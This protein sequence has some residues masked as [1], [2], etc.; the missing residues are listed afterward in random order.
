MAEKKA[1]PGLTIKKE[2]DFSGWYHELVSKCGLIDYSGIPGC[3]IL[4]PDA[5]FVWEQI[6]NFVNERIKKEGVCNAYFPLFIEE[7]KLQVEVDH[8]DG[9]KPEV[10]WVTE[11]GESQLEKRIA[12]RPT[13]E[14]AICPVVKN[15]IR[16]HRDLPL[17]LNQWCNV[18]RWEFKDCIPFIRSREFLWQEGHTFHKNRKDAEE[19]VTKMLEVYKDVYQD[20]L[21][22]PCIPGFKT[23][24]EKFDGADYST[25]VELFVPEAKK[26]IQG[27]TSHHLGQRFSKMFDITYNSADGQKEH[28]YQ[29]SWGITTRAIGSA[30]MIHSDDGGVVYPPEV[31]PIQ[32]VIV[33]IIG[34][35]TADD[36]KKGIIELCEDLIDNMDKYRCHLDDRMNITPGVK[37]NEWEQKGVPIRIEIG[38]RDFE[39]GDITVLRRD[40]ME[41]KTYKCIHVKQLFDVMND[42][43]NN[44][45]NTALDK[46]NRHSFTSTQFD[47]FLEKIDGRIGLTPWC[48][49]EECEEKFC[50]R[51]KETC[52]IK[53]LCIPFE[54]KEIEGERCIQCN[55]EARHWVY[56]GR[57]Y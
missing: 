55:K 35:K 17:K 6:Q 38:A 33:P 7:S 36:I 30:L 15:W 13:S 20:I 43:S 31:A 10:A 12:V 42:I 4:R 45:F 32:I 9:F 22:V 3:Y 11:H 26:A 21:C 39:K 19:E 52:N 5:Y 40:T 54:Q 14:T 29:N 24:N 51:V 1:S 46:L 57:S 18:V 53:S 41:K 8:L 28:T 37:F 48:D 27:A 2:E 25:T 50:D 34:K 49:D 47:D 16:S 23:K 56:W 44:L